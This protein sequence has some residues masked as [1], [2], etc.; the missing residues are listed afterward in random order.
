[1]RISD[2]LK[3]F[4]SES[5]KVAA[6]PKE[7]MPPEITLEEIQIREVIDRRKALN[8]KIEALNRKM[9]EVIDGN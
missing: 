5:V 1:M 8:R 3:Y 7:F 4:L 9:E 2:C 6:V